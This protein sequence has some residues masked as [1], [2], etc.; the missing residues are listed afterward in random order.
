VTTAAIVWNG[1]V[2][3]DTAGSGKTASHAIGEV[4]DFDAA[5]DV[6]M[7]EVTSRDSGDHKEY[8]AGLDGGQVSVTARYLKSDSG[9][10]DTLWTN[11]RNKTKFA[12][13]VNMDDDGSN[14][15]YGIYGDG[16]LKSM[17]ISSSV[18]DKVDLKFTFQFTGAITYDADSV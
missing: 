18:G 1:T 17:P 5:W 4:V 10:Q 15:G 11:F 7:V 2:Y 14:N 6:N 16:F 8:L 13:R 12:L 3:I 9:G